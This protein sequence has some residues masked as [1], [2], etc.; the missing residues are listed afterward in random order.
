MS[1]AVHL[2]PCPFCGDTAV[3]HVGVSGFD[4]AQIRCVGCGSESATFDVDDCSPDEEA[5]NIAAAVAVWNRRV[6][7]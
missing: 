1:G 2:A 5:Q 4:T 3:L 7:P 6:K